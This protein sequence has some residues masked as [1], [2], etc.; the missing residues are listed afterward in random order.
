[1]FK[2]IKIFLKKLFKKKKKKKKIKN[3]KI[4]ETIEVEEDLV[5]VKFID[6]FLNEL[7]FSSSIVSLSFFSVNEIE[8]Y[9][10]ILLYNQLIDSIEL[11]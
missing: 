11:P 7:E 8:N 10:K 1:M 2:K 9:L 3:E 6:E 5:D 4:I